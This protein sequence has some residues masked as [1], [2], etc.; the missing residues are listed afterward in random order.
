MPDQYGSHISDR[1]I[2][3]R[4]DALPFTPL[5]REL[6]EGHFVINIPT[7]LV[8][9]TRTVFN[10]V[11]DTAH[12]VHLQ[13]LW[14]VSWQ[15]TVDL[16][17]PVLAGLPPGP[18]VLDIRGEKIHSMDHV[19]SNVA[20]RGHRVYLP[21]NRNAADAY[22]N[23]NDHSSPILVQRWKHG[24]GTLKDVSVQLQSP[25]AALTPL[26]FTNAVL[27]FKY[28]VSAWAQ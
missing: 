7:Q 17:D 5:S 21:W 24:D 18:L 14:I 4:V 10:A 1:G 27:I 13:D 12:S 6:P 25:T 23:M 2:S 19:F 9:Q 22:T 11:A 28:T 3:R 16:S 20:G 26:T 15:V 8:T